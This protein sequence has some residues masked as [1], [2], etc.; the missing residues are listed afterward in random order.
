MTL[1][2]A[3]DIYI[4]TDCDLDGAMCHTMMQWYT[5]S[6]IKYQVTRVDDFR[7]TFNR[8]A[9]N[10]LDKFKIVYILDLDV[11]SCIDL[12]DKPN[13]TIIDHHDSHVTNRGKYKNAK[14]HIEKE[15]SCAKLLYNI[16][17]TSKVDFMTKEK[18]LLLGLVDDYDSYTLK[19]PISRDLNTI[20]WSYQGDRVQKFIAD[21]NDGFNGFTSK[22]KRILDF[23][24]K[25]LI[26]TIR[27]M[28]VYE[29]EKFEYDE[30]IYSICSA[31][32]TTDINEVASYLLNKYKCDIS[33]IVNTNSKKVSFRKNKSTAVNLAHFANKICGGAG[34]TDA[35][36]GSFNDRFLEFSKLF[37]RIK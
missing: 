2:L 6:H 10:N 35:A 26:E 23:K 7:S 30:K 19:T 11:S 31:V 1:P 9:S 21:W 3:K 37:N 34:H 20:F 29:L 36:G 27:E 17:S 33:I 13:I 15:T 5:R 4:F 12:V 16:L 25:A 18:R 8:W 32:A 14:V 22:H 28:E 24:N